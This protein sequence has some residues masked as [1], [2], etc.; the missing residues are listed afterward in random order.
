M[1]TSGVS[2]STIDVLKYEEVRVDEL[3]MTGKVILITG[4]SRGLG[5]S[6]A[7]GF[8]RHGANVAIVSRKIDSCIET[9]KEV[10]A[11]GVKA[12]PYA[13]HA[14]DWA[15]LDS[16]VD[17]VYA[18]FGKVDVLINNAGMSPLY[19]SL[20]QVSEELFD[21]IVGVNLKGPFRLSSNLGSS[22]AP[23]GGG[24]LSMFPA[25]HQ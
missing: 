19:P 1:Q 12:F 2:L 18:E 9:A 11:H 22:M 24:R 23:W 6:M 21:K 13:A 25:R 14:G 20:D 17:A 15:S 7:L 5:K 8:A 16:M 4:G 3:D 10:E